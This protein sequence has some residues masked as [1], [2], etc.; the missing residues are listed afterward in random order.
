MNKLLAH[1]FYLAISSLFMSGILF[2]IPFYADFFFANEITFTPSASLL[3]RIHGAMAMVLLIVF[4]GIWQLHI[5]SRIKNKKQR[6]S[7]LSFIVMLL[8]LILTAYGLYYSGSIEWRE[9]ISH[10]HTLFGILLILP[11][12]WHVIFIKMKKS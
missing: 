6:S 4:G 1:L 12:C 3:M 2:A 9:V 11:M 8:V 7:G 10:I 5:N